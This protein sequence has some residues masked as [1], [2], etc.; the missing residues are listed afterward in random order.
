VSAKNIQTAGRMNATLTAHKNVENMRPVVSFLEN[1]MPVVIDQTTAQKLC[2]VFKTPCL[3]LSWWFYPTLW[4]L[5]IHLY[6]VCG[7]M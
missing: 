5:E 4:C 2:P 6:D 7:A 3:G 1:M